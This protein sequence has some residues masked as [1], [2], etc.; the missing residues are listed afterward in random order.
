MP[1]GCCINNGVSE[2][3]AASPRELSVRR[4]VI[5]LFIAVITATTYVREYLLAGVQTRRGK[6]RL[7]YRNNPLIC[8]NA[9]SLA[10]LLL[11]GPVSTRPKC[12]KGRWYFALRSVFVLRNCRDRSRARSLGSWRSGVIGTSHLAPYING[13]CLS[14]QSRITVDRRATTV[15]CATECPAR[16]KGN[17]RQHLR[18]I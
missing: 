5:A 14:K 3:L 8:T 6:R 7:E 2:H 13:T 17:S 10:H 9:R 15:A 1:V 4:A 12:E 18:I 16:T 11:F